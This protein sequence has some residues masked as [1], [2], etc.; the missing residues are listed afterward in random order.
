M[1]PFYF[2]IIAPRK[3]ANRANTLFCVVWATLASFIATI[4]SSTVVVKV[5][6][7]Y[8]HPGMHVMHA[9]TTVLARPIAYLAEVFNKFLMETVYVGV[10]EIANQRVVLTNLLYK[11]I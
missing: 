10:F 8:M 4:S 1:R 5:R 3:G 6:L 2:S 7:A 9:V 11:T